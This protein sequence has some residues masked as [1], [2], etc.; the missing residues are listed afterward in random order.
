MRRRPMSS[1]RARR[2]GGAQPAAQRFV[3]ASAEPPC[4]AG[5]GR[6]RQIEGRD[7]FRLRDAGRAGPGIGRARQEDRDPA[8]LDALDLEADL[9]VVVEAHEDD[10]SITLLTLHNVHT[11]ARL[12]AEV[13]SA[14]AA[15]RLAEA[16]K[17]WVGD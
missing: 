10:D 16:E 8:A 11:M 14:I 9:A 5:D 6:D 2:P 1:R 12:M 4:H 7:A 3:G 13:R 17:E 15:G